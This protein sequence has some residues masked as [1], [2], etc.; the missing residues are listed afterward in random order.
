MFSVH[1]RFIDAIDVDDFPVDAGSLAATMDPGL[2]SPM[3]TSSR[4]VPCTLFLFDDAVLVA[5]RN[6]PHLSGRQLLGLDNLDRL[7]D[8]MKTFT[9]KSGASSSQQSRKGELSFRGVSDIMDV[10][11][12][13]LGGPGKWSC[14]HTG[15]MKVETDNLDVSSSPID[16]QLYFKKEPAHIHHEKW[17]NRPLRQYTVL[18]DARSESPPRFEKLRFIENLW[19]ARALHKARDRRSLL[20]SM[21]IPATSLGG[22]ESPGGVDAE[23]RRVVY[24]TV[25]NSRSTYQEEANR[26]AVLLHYDA[27][28]SSRAGPGKALEFAGHYA[29][30]RLHSI[31]EEYGE[32]NY[33]VHIRNQPDDD[34]EYV[35]P[36]RD[37]A[38]RMRR[39]HDSLMLPEDHL[40]ASNLRPTE[41][42]SA[43]HRGRMAA[44]LESF[45]RSLFSG[46]PESIRFGSPRRKGSILSKSS[47]ATSLASDLFS[48]SGRSVSTAGTSVNSRDMLSMASRGPAVDGQGKLLPPGSQ[49]PR[50]STGRHQRAISAGTI[51]MVMSTHAEATQTSSQRQRPMSV[52]LT[53]NAETPIADLSLTGGSLARRVRASSVGDATTETSSQPVVDQ[54]MAR[55]RVSTRPSGPRAVPSTS[56]RRKA[57]PAFPESNSN[58]PY[59]PTRRV[60]SAS[61]RSAPVD[62]DDD[63][64]AENNSVRPGSTDHPETKGTA[65]ARSRA[66]KRTA[67][68]QTYSDGNDAPSLPEKDT[69]SPLQPRK[70][71]VQQQRSSGTHNGAAAPS[72]TR[73][74]LALAMKGRVHRHLARLDEADKENLDCLTGLAG[75]VSELHGAA[76]ELD[77]PL[78][79]DLVHRMETWIA[80]TSDRF[81]DSKASISRVAGDV[82]VLLQRLEEYERELEDGG[83][84]E[85]TTETAAAAAAAMKRVQELEAK[86][87]ESSVYRTRCEALQ[88]KCELLTALEKDGRLENGELH[89]AFNEEL[90]RMYDDAQLSSRDEEVRALREEVKKTKATRNDL[91]KRNWDLERDSKVQ[92]GQIES[93]EKI[94]RQH[95]L[96]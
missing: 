3:S 27:R 8:E 30:L 94:L 37:L 31:D 61:K 24:W 91:Q 56:P 32:C 75:E 10:T 21:V 71:A 14:C 48:N 40:N 80:D 36:L 83:G 49:S 87:K 51:D 86:V 58:I 22:N 7:A 81:V 72:S 59:T 66:S 23:P 64:D 67:Y 74:P 68:N 54:N 33:S 50:A 26:T 28:E 88:R 6:N 70:K 2:F 55:Q 79:G 96:L 57:V 20:R 25:Y 11:A 41:A 12:T 4:A 18:A 76:S 35:L 47:V 92:K 78:L 1:R 46:T 85:E 9:E 43:S 84:Q 29:Q 90:D 42:S 34:D 16:L 63:D 45:G 52:A 95:G 38:K 62:D 39:L 89:K 13:D 60:P 19:R 77:S 65:D 73:R 44:G 5:K 69:V 82:E 17:T 53:A 93:Y 15:S